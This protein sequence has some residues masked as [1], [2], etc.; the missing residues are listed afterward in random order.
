[1]QTARFGIAVPPCAVT[2]THSPAPACVHAV[3]GFSQNAWHV[4]K[5]HVRPCAQP[6]VAVHGLPIVA[7]PNATHFAVPFVSTTSHV[8]VFAQPH[9]GTTP[10][11]L[12]GAAVLQFDGGGS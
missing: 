10:H 11:A 12:L 1:M 9:W 2:C 8:S 6:A 5:T 7:L 3:P 4:P